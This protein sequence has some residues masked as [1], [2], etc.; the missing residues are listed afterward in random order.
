MKKNLLALSIAAALL[1]S[2][3]AIAATAGTSYI[4]VRAGVAD[5]DW[6][7]AS[8]TDIYTKDDDSGYGLGLYLGYSFSDYFSLEGGYN[9]F[10]GAKAS[11][12]VTSG[13]TTTTQVKDLDV[14]GPEVSVRLSL[15][16]SDNGSDLFVRG[17]GMYAF[18]DGGDDKFV[19]V[20][21]IGASIAVSESVDL[22]LGVDRYFDV[23]D[24]DNQTKGIEFDLNYA[25]LG[26]NY[27]MGRAAPAPA[28]Q[29]PV[30]QTVTTSYALDANTLFGFDSDKLTAEGSAAVDQVVTEAQ[31]LDGATYNV[32]GYTD[33]IGNPAYNQKLSERRAGAVAA[34]LQA[35]GV[36]A[37]AIQAVGY[38]P[39]DPV[40]GAE[41]DG[42]AGK[43]LIKCLAPDRRVVINVSGTSSTTE[44][45]K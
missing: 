43:E 19:P 31:K 39:A 34:E 12:D 28:P 44:T 2:T 37:D 26:V 38:G 32:A 21:G 3:S 27:V 30:T 7:N 42:V 17:G 6:G 13:T 33:R 4:G 41:C 25:Y 40:T 45:I 10:T 18:N 35:K 29:D 24:A 15:P 8:D 11:K 20:A 22:R 5:F 1:A 23:Y 9:Y 14:H 16:I 36:P